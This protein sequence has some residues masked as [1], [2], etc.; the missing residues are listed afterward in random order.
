MLLLV[1]PVN[2]R[3][4]FDATLSSLVSDQLLLLLCAVSLKRLPPFVGLYDKQERVVSLLSNG[5]S[6]A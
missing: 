1:N 3:P 4:V 5:I 2:V 6:I